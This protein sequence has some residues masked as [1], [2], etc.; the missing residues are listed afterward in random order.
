[1]L[2]QTCHCEAPLSL[3]CSC[4]GSQY[5]QQ[6][7]MPSDTQQQQATDSTTHTWQQLGLPDGRWVHNLLAVL[8]G[9]DTLDP[10]ISVQGLARF[11]YHTDRQQSH[12]TWFFH[13]WWIATA[14]IINKNAL[15]QHRFGHVHRSATL[16]CDRDCPSVATAA[17]VLAG[18]KHSNKCSRQML[19]YQ[20]P[21][22]CGG[23]E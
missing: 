14:I 16:Q 20:L 7:K 5:S 2:W 19:G 1:M 10:C 15:A 13:G 4:P 11:L 18:H 12:H 21:Q 22:S 17:H 23:C 3:L 6:L 8:H 9:C